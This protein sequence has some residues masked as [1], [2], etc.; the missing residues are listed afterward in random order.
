MNLSTT[1][2]SAGK[3][4]AF[5]A[6]LAF[7][8]LIFVSH[9][10]TANGGNVRG[11]TGASRRLGRTPIRATD[12]LDGFRAL[13]SKGLCSGANIFAKF[14]S[15]DYIKLGAGIADGRKACR[16]VCDAVKCPAF[17]YAP[18]GYFY[19][20]N[21][22]WMGIRYR[23]TPECIVYHDYGEQLPGTHYHRTGSSR[24]FDF[25]PTTTKWIFVD[26]NWAS[27]EC[28]VS[29]WR[30]NLNHRGG[31]ERRLGLWKKYKEAAGA[32]WRLIRGKGF[33]NVKNGAVQMMRNVRLRLPAR[34]GRHRTYTN[35]VQLD[36]FIHGVEDM[37]GGCYPHADA[38][39]QPIE[40]P[41]L[42]EFDQPGWD[43][44]GGST[45]HSC[46]PSTFYEFISNMVNK[47]V[48]ALVT[49]DDVD[50]Y[51]WF[52]EWWTN[53]AGGP[54]A[55]KNLCDASQG[56]SQHQWRVN[57]PFHPP[58]HIRPDS[59]IGFG[60]DNE[61]YFVN[62]THSDPRNRVGTTNGWGP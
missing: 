11:A 31:H 50:M 17:N 27:G 42:D 25:V 5:V 19:P 10:A 53:P 9:N 8:V 26:W 56:Q 51:C 41:A 28:F 46:R 55:A 37:Q 21:F 60:E 43:Q 1:A 6:T 2:R 13:E 22:W 14:P 45:A 57:Q 48:G 3:T 35:N 23:P 58:R 39:H 36:S 18:A 29:N 40:Q 49:Q 12:K 15:Y 24:A 32:A 52:Y 61:Q 54:E 16:R 47:A 20:G 7:L 4:I 62:P 38:A 33:A 59:G 44:G 34:H 30:E